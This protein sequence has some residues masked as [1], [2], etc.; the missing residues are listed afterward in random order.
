MGLDGDLG[1]AELG[2]DLIGLEV[3]GHAVHAL[4]FLGR[5]AFDQGHGAMWAAGRES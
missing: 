5:Q 4:E 2:G 1:E 3:P